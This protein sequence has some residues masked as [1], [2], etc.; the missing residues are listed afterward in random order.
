M[1]EYTTD[2]PFP[3]G[4]GWSSSRTSAPVAT[5]PDDT[6]PIDDREA[7]AHALD[8]EHGDFRSFS[9]FKFSWPYRYPGTARATQW[10]V[11]TVPYWSLLLLALLF[12]L[13]AG[14]RNLRGRLRARRGLCVT[15]GYDLRA[16]P[17][18]CPECGA[19]LKK[20]EAR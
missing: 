20:V 14:R 18:R 6:V 13:A 12:P 4:S 9:V 8:L 19:I 17:D 2:Y 11:F 16:T 3:L 7:I 15:C 10:R 5:I 1:L